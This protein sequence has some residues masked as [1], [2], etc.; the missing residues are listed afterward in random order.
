MKNL[1]F[2][3]PDYENYR[4]DDV[5]DSFGG[6]TG[7]F[8]L[9]EDPTT[10]EMLV[11][12]FIDR[13]N[14]TDMSEKYNLSS[15]RIRQKID[16][17]SR[18]VKSATKNERD[19][20]FEAVIDFE[21]NNF[22]ILE[23]SYFTNTWCPAEFLSG[24]LSDIFNELPTSHNVRRNS[25]RFSNL[26]YFQYRQRCDRL[27]EN[28]FMVP[29][30]EVFDLMA[31]VPLEEDDVSITGSELSAKLHGIRFLLHSRYISCRNEKGKL[32]LAFGSDFS[33]MA[34]KLIRHYDRALSFDEIIEI[35]KPHNF[36][37]PS[38]RSDAISTLRGNPDIIQLNDE[39]FG[40][41]KH[42][43]YPPAEWDAIRKFVE[44]ILEREKKIVDLA[45]LFEE[46]IKVFDK[47]SS[48]EELG[49]ILRRAHNIQNSAGRLFAHS[50]VDISTIKTLP[51]LVSEILKSQGGIASKDQIFQ[52]VSSYR[53]YSS[54]GFTSN[55]K[56]INLIQYYEGNYYGF[57]SPDKKN[58][59]LLS[60]TPEFIC[61]YMLE[62]LHPKTTIEDIVAGFSHFNP[63]KVVATIRSDE[64]FEV[65]KFPGSESEVVICKNWSRNKIIVSIVYH[66]GE[67]IDHPT[68]CTWLV[69]LDQKFQDIQIPNLMQLGIKF[70]QNIYTYQAEKK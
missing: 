5:L 4:S 32:F 48:K 38:N 11:Q 59:Q 21:I 66:S 60:Q 50:S 70:S 28:R 17:F 69:K 45:L 27:F 30:T 44:A 62:K 19:R 6:V 23:D 51:H 34:E 18:K 55:L 64:R 10:Q 20:L 7:Y 53:S 22:Q 39:V 61:S 54:E 49:F 47:L 9:A 56:S 14:L 58:R 1:I 63:Q 43:S 57:K 41:A 35:L 25:S 65:V 29:I 24:L 8:Y 3:A 42:T 68:L 13:T 67:G 37:I 2:T 46:T 40:I 36:R 16:Q 12:R 31:K 15:E 26:P 33:D 52:Y